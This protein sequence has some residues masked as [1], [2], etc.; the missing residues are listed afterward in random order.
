MMY[1]SPIP[2]PLRKITFFPADANGWNWK[3]EVSSDGG[4]KWTEV[5]RI[6][7]SPRR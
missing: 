6:K 2:D 4:E 3:L 5:Y 1:K 7:A